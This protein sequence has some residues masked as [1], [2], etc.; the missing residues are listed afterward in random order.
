MADQSHINDMR[1]AVR[2]DLERA[3]ARNPAIFEHAL[4]VQT[5][6]PQAETPAEPEPVALVEPEPEPQVQ[7]EPAAEPEPPTAPEAERSFFARLF[8]R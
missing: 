2:G 3:R 1:A 5:P 8:R 4:A 6:E 7:P